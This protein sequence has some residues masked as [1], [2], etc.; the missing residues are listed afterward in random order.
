[1][2]FNIGSLKKVISLHDS[3]TNQKDIILIMISTVQ[4]FFGGSPGGDEVNLRGKDFFSVMKL[5]FC[6]LESKRTI[7]LNGGRSAISMLDEIPSVHNV[8]KTPR[9]IYLDCVNYAVNGSDR[10]DYEY[11][12][13]LIE[14]V[15]EISSFVFISYITLDNFEIAYD[16]CNVNHL[17]DTQDEKDN[18]EFHISNIHTVLSR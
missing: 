13:K 12:K 9:N 5:A 1:M 6:L 11:T 4:S 15:D 7:Y 14:E 18:F 3:D 17:F 2:S 10:Y 8:A 16:A